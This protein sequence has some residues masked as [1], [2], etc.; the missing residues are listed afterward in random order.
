[1]ARIFFPIVLSMCRW[2]SKV[3]GRVSAAPSLP[4]D[5]LGGLTRRQTL[6]AAVDEVRHTLARL[7]PDWR[8]L[9]LPDALTGEARDLYATANSLLHQANV[10]ESR[11]ACAAGS[12]AGGRRV[13]C[14][15]LDVLHDVLD[16]RGGALRG[17]GL[18][19][20]PA[21]RPRDRVARRRD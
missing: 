11:A 9:D 17:R 15:L 1:M 2:C 13:L 20:L 10:E 3:L 12:P 5:E 18:V 19:E 4:A 21:E 7:A 14:R 6:L 8:C 16:G